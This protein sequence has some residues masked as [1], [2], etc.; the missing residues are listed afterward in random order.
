MPTSQFLDPEVLRS[1]AN[2]ELRARVLVEGM[3]ASRHRSPYYGYSQEFVDHREYAPGDEPK[4][5]DWKMVARTEKY[6]VKRFEMESNMN[7][8]ALLDVSGSMGYESSNEARLSKLEYGSFLAA[9]LAFLVN[10]QQDS[11][12]LV[13]FDENIRDLVP[14]KQG[15]RNLHT[16]LSK[17]Q[18]TEPGGR[19]DVGDVLKAISQRLKNNGIVLIISDC[20]GDPENVAEGVRHLLVRGQDVIIFH[21]MD[22]DEVTFPFKSL[23]SFRDME[24]GQEVMSDPLRQK[25][26]YLNK[27]EAFREALRSSITS[28]GAD[29]RFVDTVDPLETVLRDYLLY[30]E[31]T[32]R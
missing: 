17:L 5:I 7:V 11:P 28:A 3:Y 1:L 30:R 32:M 13:T 25:Q 27:F 26:R 29:Y 22:H 19:T 12:G 14:P 21:L 4:M 9:S 24:T 10:K 2:I 15:D 8:V 31:Q 6:F 16:I 23:T 18:D 20:Y